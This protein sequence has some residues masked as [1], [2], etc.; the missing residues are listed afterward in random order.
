MKLTTTIQRSVLMTLIALFGYSLTTVGQA[1]LVVNGANVKLTSGT[2][3]VNGDLVVQSG[4]VTGGTSTISTTGSV[5]LNGGTLDATTGTMSVGG[6]FTYNTATFNHNYGKV[7]FNG[8]SAQQIN[9]SGR[10]AFHDIDINNNLSIETTDTTKV[11]GVIKL[12]SAKTL[13]ADGSNGNR[14][15]KLQSIGDYP[16][17]QDASIAAIPAGASVSG[18]ITVERYMSN[19]K[20]TNTGRFYRYISAPVANATIADLQNEI[21]V[22]GNFTGRSTCTAERMSS[23]TTSQ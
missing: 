12:L 2:L 14:I 19:V 8:S 4:K 18:N 13:D 20:S 22:T 17:S 5:T 6:N 7:L 15:L 11:S 9:G 16:Y 23:S 1:K 3:K 21:S 10:P